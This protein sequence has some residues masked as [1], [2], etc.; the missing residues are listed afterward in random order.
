MMPSLR[1]V[2]LSVLVASLPMQ[3]LIPQQTSDSTLRGTVLTSETSEPI[4]YGIVEVHG[5]AARLTDETGHFQIGPLRPGSYRLLVRQIGYLP[6]DST[7]TIP[8][9][10]VR[11]RL[12]R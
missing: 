7:V 8:A 4:A 1:T 5:R 2:P 9:A 3:R 12:K 6:F 11:I 10:P